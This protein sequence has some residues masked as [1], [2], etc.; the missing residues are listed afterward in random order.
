[1]AS[2]IADPGTAKIGARSSVRFPYVPLAYALDLAQNLYDRHGGEA[3]S[4]EIAATVGYSPTSSSYRNGLAAARLFG[5]L[6]SGSATVALTDLGKAALDPEECRPALIR[7]FLNVPLYAELYERFQGSV[8]PSS[9][10]LESVMQDLGV[11]PKSASKARLAFRKSAD[12]AG[13]LTN[14]NRLVRPRA[15]Q[16]ALLDEADAEVETEESAPQVHS[17]PDIPGGPRH[18]VLRSLLSMLPPDRFDSQAEKEKWVGAFEVVF[19]MAY[20]DEA[21]EEVVAGSEGG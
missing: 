11:A 9:A 8:L 5:L 7:A 10:G 13:F 20:P 18:P 6:K 15:G 3:P 12:T 2:E 16:T 14:D 17:P 4:E 1:M 19:D 21:G